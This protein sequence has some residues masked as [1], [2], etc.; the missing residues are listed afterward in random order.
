MQSF[1]QFIL[2]ENKLTAEQAAAFIQR[3]CKKFLADSNF[4][5]GFHLYRG[6]RTA[7]ESFK[8]V[9]TAQDR[10]PK[11][12]P[13]KNHL[14]MDKFFKLKFGIKFRSQSVFT[15][16]SFGHAS[17]YGLVHMIFPVGDYKFVWGKDVE[18]AFDRFGDMDHQELYN[19]LVNEKDVYIDTDLPKAISSQ[20]EI[21]VHCDYYYALPIDMSI[22]REKSREFAKEVTHILQK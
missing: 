5:I 11:D 9:R 3:D 13:I 4:K 21:M 7:D 6:I 20:N 2:E 17:S 12:M 16:G 22:L 18:D 8:R 15:T 1:K 14:A 10:I 19:Y